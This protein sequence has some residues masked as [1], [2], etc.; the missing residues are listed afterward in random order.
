MLK[1]QI[2]IFRGERDY[3]YFYSV[4]NK[5]R[6][7]FLGVEETIYCFYSIFEKSQI[8]FVGVTENLNAFGCFF[9][10]AVSSACCAPTRHSHF[11]LEGVAPRPHRHGKGSTHPSSF[12]WRTYD[13][14]AWFGLSLRI[15]SFQQCRKCT[16]SKQLQIDYSSSRVYSLIVSATM[17]DL[18][19][20][21]HACMQ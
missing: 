2:S 13:G 10:R 20:I 7:Q 21:Q 4:F 9:M 11:Q 19:V 5:S 8:H 6:M 14:F 17:C 3:Y 16:I 15:F 18:S 12:S 1:T